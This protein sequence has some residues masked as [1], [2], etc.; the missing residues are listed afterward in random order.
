LDISSIFSRHSVR[1]QRGPRNEH[2]T[3]CDAA[4]EHGSRQPLELASSLCAQSARRPAYTL[5]LAFRLTSPSVPRPR[6]LVFPAPVALSSSAENRPRA[7]MLFSPPLSARPTPQNCSAFT[8]LF[9]SS[10]YSN[11]LL[12]VTRFPSLSLSPRSPSHVKTPCVSP[13]FE[14]HFSIALN[15]VFTLSIAWLAHV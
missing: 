14:P 6:H 2:C 8:L 13:P 15:Y 3:N 12:L 4:S 7:D 1:W 9:Y 11:L 10:I 5:V